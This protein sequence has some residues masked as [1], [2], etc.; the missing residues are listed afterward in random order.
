MKALLQETLTN[1]KAQVF[2]WDAVKEATKPLADSLRERL[3]GELLESYRYNKSI[4]VE[5]QYLYRR[6]HSPHKSP[7]GVSPWQN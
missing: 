6:T 5:F 7:R 3:K 2:S 1:L 4:E